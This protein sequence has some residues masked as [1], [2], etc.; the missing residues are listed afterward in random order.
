MLLDAGVKPAK[1]MTKSPRPLDFPKLRLSVP[2]HE[3]GWVILDHIVVDL[4]G[5]LWKTKYHRESSALKLR[6][7]R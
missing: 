3:R 4:N 1:L 2:G 6:D 7:A 5:G